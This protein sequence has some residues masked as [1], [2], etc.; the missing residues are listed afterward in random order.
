[1][2]GEA[3]AC[4]AL[5]WGHGPR[6]LDVFLEPTC[7]YSARAFAKFRALLDGVGEDRMT[8]RLRMQSQPWHL[9][10]GVMVRAILAASAT[11]GGKDAAWRVMHEI[12][13][14]RDAFE[15]DNHSGGPNLDVSPSEMLARLE[16]MTGIPLGEAFALETVTTA[17]KRHARF[18]RQNGIHVSPT[19]MIDG[20]IAD[21][22]SSG[23]PVE[24]WRGALGL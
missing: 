24:K 9:F 1:M 20:L 3:T 22:V 6:M 15:C 2:T 17:M 21:G 11:P 16:G 12:F 19:F 18:A 13:T 4:E 14:H 10:S 23:D 8:L 5:D 7:P